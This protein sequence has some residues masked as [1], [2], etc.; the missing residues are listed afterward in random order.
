MNS[1]NP[2]L[3]L[4]DPKTL[5]ALRQAFDGAWVMI[6]ARDPFRDFER[7]ES[8]KLPL[9]GSFRGCLRMA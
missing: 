4:Y 8:L 7:T 6:Q 3:D 2:R 5:E 1:P 9:V